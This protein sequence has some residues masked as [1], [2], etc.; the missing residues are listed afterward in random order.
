LRSQFVISSFEK[1]NWITI[2][3]TAAG[4]RDIT[5]IN[6]TDR[7]SQL[8]KGLW[9]SK[10]RRQSTS[11]LRRVGSQKDPAD[12]AFRVGKVVGLKW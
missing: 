10:D 12:V 2:R 11:R 3:I 4:G 5:K 8:R 6:V 1:I 7:V 9:P